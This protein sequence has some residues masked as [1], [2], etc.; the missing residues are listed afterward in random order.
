MIYALKFTAFHTDN[1]VSITI[2]PVTYTTKD[3]LQKDHEVYDT[4]DDGASHWLVVS[5]DLKGQQEIMDLQEVERETQVAHH[6]D[7][8]Y[9]MSSKEYLG[10]LPF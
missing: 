1:D 5:Q 3:D 4:Y 9:F 7:S 8:G 2:E 6:M 10:F